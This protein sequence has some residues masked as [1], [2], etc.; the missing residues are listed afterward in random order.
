MNVHVTRKGYRD[1]AEDTRVSIQHSHPT[2]VG[3]RQKESILPPTAVPCGSATEATKERRGKSG[4]ED[5]G[6]T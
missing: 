6:E 3:K 2:L 5:R 4:G 1:P